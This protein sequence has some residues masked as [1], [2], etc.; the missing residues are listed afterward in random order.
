[1][2]ILAVSLLAVAMIGVMVPSVLGEV[3]IN[4]TKF[5][6][7]S[8]EYPSDWEIISTENVTGEGIMIDL[9]KTG[10]NGMW[11]GLWKNSIEPNV[12][13]YELMEFQKNSVRLFCDES[14]Q[15]E[16]FGECSH[17][18]FLQN[19]IWEIDGFRA[20]TSLFKYDWEMKQSDPLFQDST[21]GKFSPM[22]TLTWIISGDDMWIIATTND[23]DK[24]DK[25]QIH[26]II[27]SFKL[28]NI[29]PATISEPQAKSWFDS[30][31]EIFMQMLG[32]IGNFH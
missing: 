11:I 9:D 8:I 10:R 7:F 27:Q 3:F 23:I 28:K 13:D 19:K 6:P 17:L 15:E 32:R 14:T 21:M 4:E 26:E 22:D 24:F 20:V 25:K 16:D 31:I 18:G 30:I 29:E 5:Y 2:T 1:M 12:G